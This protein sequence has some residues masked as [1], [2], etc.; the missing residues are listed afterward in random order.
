MIFTYVYRFHLR[1]LCTLLDCEE[2]NDNVILFSW[3]L[4][5]NG[6]QF[7]L[8]FHRGNLLCWKWK[9]GLRGQMVMEPH[10]EKAAHGHNRRVMGEDGLF[11]RATLACV[12]THLHTCLFVE[13]EASSVCVTVDFNT[14]ETLCWSH[15][16]STVEWWGNFPCYVPVAMK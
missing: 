9:I 3:L 16:S 1:H 7:V 5:S 15:W 12:R 10:P 6:A 14:G 2:C 13:N 11:I 4:V 8:V